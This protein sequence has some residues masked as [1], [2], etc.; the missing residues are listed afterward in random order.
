MQLRSNIRGKTKIGY[1]VSADRSGRF[2]Y[3]RAGE[4]PIGVITEVVTRGELCEI[5]TTGEALVY[6]YGSIGANE[7]LRSPEISEGVPAGAAL[8]LGDKTIYTAIGQAL[9]TGKGL[10]RVSINMSST[11]SIGP[12]AGVPAGGSTSQVL[13]KLSAADYDTGWTTP[14]AAYTAWDLQTGG[15]TRESITDGFELDFIGDTTYIQVQYNATDDRLEFSYIG[16]TD[17]YEG[18]DL[19]VDSV[20]TTR[21]ITSRM[22]VNFISGTYTTITHNFVTGPPPHNDIT[23]DIDQ[24][25]LDGRYYTQ[26]AADALFYTQTYINSNF[27]NYGGWDLWTT[28]LQETIVSGGKVDFRGDG[29]YIQVQYTPATDI[30]EVSYVGPTDFYLGWDPGTDTGTGHTRVGSAHDVNIVG[31][32]Y[33]TTA[34]AFATSV[35]TITVSIDQTVFNAAYYT[36]TAAD[37]LFATQTWVTNNFD[38]YGGWDLW[39]TVFR[40]TIGSGD[41]VDFIGG[42]D[43]SAVWSGAAKTLTISYTGTPGNM[44]DWYLNVNTGSDHTIQNHTQVDFKNGTNITAVY[45]F[46]APRH[47]VTFN[48]NSTISLTSVTTTTSII[49]DTIAERTGGSGVTADGVLLKDSLAGVTSTLYSTTTSL[50]MGPTGS[51]NVYIRP[52]GYGSATA[53]SVFGAT[54]ATIG[55]TLNV[56]SLAASSDISKFTGANV[57]GYSRV[58][59]NTVTTVDAQLSFQEAASTKWTIGNNADN[60][61]FVIRKGFGAFGTNDYFTILTTGNIT[62]PG[63][64]AAEGEI[65]SYDTSDIRLKK[66]IEELDPVK[67]IEALMKLRTV[68]YI[69]K[70]KGKVEIGMISQEAMVDF[71]ENIKKDREGHLLLHYGKMVPPLLAMNQNQEIRLREV[72]RRLGI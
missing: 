39:T 51:G 72:E 1:L 61:A 40:E 71:P 50:F 29:T 20:D 24:T 14:A 16:P 43:I 64:L 54:S 44:D 10:V 17:F 53:Q 4:V 5:Q 3:A 52:S 27:D 38:N 62:M 18:W 41:K 70:T 12:S 65:E 49:T 23:I 45:S 25:A 60:D 28:V 6:V 11:T 34:Y 56:T 63:S 59:I 55:N 32:T 26:T 30:L 57:S 15:I 21:I 46:S 19:W 68:R 36:Q 47:E 66:I 2:V 35:H 67:T 22:D 9:E 42:T 13:T 33:L 7:T 31:G 48:L 69:H 8:P 58:V 37:A